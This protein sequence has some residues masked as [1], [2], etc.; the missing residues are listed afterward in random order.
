M[1]IWSV[2]ASVVV[3]ALSAGWIVTARR[4]IRVDQLG[5]VSRQ[6]ITDH[7]DQ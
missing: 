2:L 6:W 7:I 5:S 3:V 1:I 4:P